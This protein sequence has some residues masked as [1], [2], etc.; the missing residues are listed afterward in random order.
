LAAAT[1]E[2]AE[3]SSA[4]LAEVNLFSDDKDEEEEEEEAAVV[5]AAPTL[6]RRSARAAVVAVEEEE[7]EEEGRPRPS[8]LSGM[9]ERD[10]EPQLITGKTLP[11]TSIISNCRPERILD[12]H[13]I[14]ERAGSKNEI[15]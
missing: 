3:G 4:A 2:V 13:T 14:L 11:G 10:E 9:A 15:Y 7:E 6:N 5:A 8:I 1:A 12:T